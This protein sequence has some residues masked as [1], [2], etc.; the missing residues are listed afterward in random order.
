MLPI[1][2]LYSAILTFTN[3]P[4]EEILSLPWKHFIMFLRLTIDSFPN[5]YFNRKKSKPLK[6]LQLIVSH[7]FCI[8]FPIV[9][10]KRATLRTLKKRE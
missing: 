3:I 6:P 10:Y 9:S 2:I 8:F 7:Y 1:S 4:Q 5:R